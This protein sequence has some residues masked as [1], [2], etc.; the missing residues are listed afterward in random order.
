MA[1][2]PKGDLQHGLGAAAPKIDL[3]LSGG[4]YRAAFGALGVIF[5]LL[6]DN[7]WPLVRRI[8]SVSGGGIVNAWLAL[9][10]PSEADLAGELSKIFDDLTSRKRTALVLVVAAVPVL[11]IILG[12]GVAFR[13]IAG[14]V[15]G[16]GWLKVLVLVLALR[17]GLRGFLRLALY[18]LYRRMV[19]TTRLDTISGQPWTRE[20]VFVAT[21]LSA[22][23]A[24][25]F[26]A[27]AIQPSVVSTSRGIFDGRRVT[28]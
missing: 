7:R 9:A 2:S 14:E 23:G 11:A 20:H 12:A 1:E 5:F 10:R 18:A 16:W 27:N 6:T 25:Y 24:V 13:E 22:H 26:V 21:D 4:G 15:S 8:T 28:W 19:G 17:L 3:F